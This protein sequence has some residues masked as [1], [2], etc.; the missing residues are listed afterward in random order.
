ME[1]SANGISFR[2]AAD[3]T[4]LADSGPSGTPTAPGQPVIRQDKWEARVL[5]PMEKPTVVFSADDLRDK[6]KMQVEVTATRL[7]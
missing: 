2:L 1:E 4:S 3:V 7:D 6:G 5:V